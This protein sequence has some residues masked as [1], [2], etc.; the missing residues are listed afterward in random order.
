[1]QITSVIAYKLQ[2]T[3]LIELERGKRIRNF[4]EISYERTVSR[5]H[6]RANEVNSGMFTHTD[7]QPPYPLNAG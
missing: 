2:Q 1:M 7:M 3:Y 4:E 6:L 5:L